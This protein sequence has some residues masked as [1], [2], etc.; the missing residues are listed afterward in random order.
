MRLFDTM[1]PFERLKKDL[2]S[3]SAWQRMLP[4]PRRQALDVLQACCDMKRP[5]SSITW[6]ISRRAIVFEWPAH[7]H[8]WCS[9]VYNTITKTWHFVTTEAGSK[10]SEAFH[11]C[12][13]LKS[14]VKRLFGKLDRIRK[15][16]G[17]KSCAS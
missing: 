8:A 1:P 5:P 3:L 13:H 2:K 4:D 11:E 14:A 9:I 17:K 10:L 15:E 7:R 16:E 12:V 6:C